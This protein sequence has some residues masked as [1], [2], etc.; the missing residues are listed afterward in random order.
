MREGLEPIPVPNSEHLINAARSPKVLLDSRPIMIKIPGILNK[1]AETNSCLK[2][3]VVKLHGEV[4]S[5]PAPTLTQQ[6]ELLNALL[7]ANEEFK[8]IIDFFNPR[9]KKAE[10]PYS[11]A[12]SLLETIEGTNNDKVGIKVAAEQAADSIEDMLIVIGKYLFERESFMEDSSFQ[13]LSSVAKLDAALLYD[14]DE[15]NLE[16]CVA[17]QKYFPD[18]G[19]GSRI[20]VSSVLNPGSSERSSPENEDIVVSLEEDISKIIDELTR[21][22]TR[23]SIVTITG[24]GGIAIDQVL[25][26]LL[27]IMSQSC[28]GIQAESIEDKAQLLYRSLKGRKYLIVVDGLW[29][30]E[31]WDAVLR[32][33]RDDNLGSRI[34]ITTRV[35]EFPASINIAKNPPHC[36][37]P[38]DK[39]QSWE[40]LEK[41]VFGQE[42]RPEELN[43][44]G[45]EIAE[46]W[47][48]ADADYF[49][50]IVV[51]S[52]N[53]LPSHL[54][55]CFIYMG[56]FP[57]NRLIVV[58]K[59]LNLWI[60]NGFLNSNSS[61]PEAENYLKGL[62]D[63]NLLRAGK[64]S[65]DGKVKTCL[66]HDPLRQV[67]LREA[68][69]ENFM[70][71]IESNAIANG[72][73]KQQHLVFN[74]EDLDDFQLLPPL[75]N[76]HSFRWPNFG[77]DFNLGM[78]LLQLPDFK[79]L[80]VLDMYFV[81]FD[82]F[83][84]ALLNL[85]NLRGL[86]LNVTY[87][88]DTSICQLLKLQTVLI[89]GPW[90]SGTPPTLYVE[91]WKMPWLR[92]V[93]VEVPSC[94]T[95][96]YPLQPILDGVLGPCNLQ[97][98]SKI[99]FSSCTKE[100]ILL[101]VNLKQL[102][103]S[104]TEEDF[105]NGELT[106]CFHNLSLLTELE[107]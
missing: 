15:D 17:I 39:H 63:R 94:L 14:L 107:T 45:K 68:Q 69:K 51:L 98:L 75:P 93:Y 2:A 3:F 31:H 29:N 28:D 22:P 47:V 83:P 86:A 85:V 59:L 32:Y 40:L 105:K 38:L 72:L 1:V 41:L 81:P 13:D 34:L 87:E 54:K 62:I 64:R 104:E 92:N 96:P 26:H 60:A 71:V 78:I 8:R 23:L 12:G 67:C 82:T 42:G 6:R 89:Y 49:L 102:G 90:V 53:H 76:L 9:V 106:K 5:H 21:P 88:L 103:V 58:E 50:D 52:Y 100:V 48:S 73:E 84:S 46:R 10:A 4:T 55:A 30:F 65:L 77:S 11:M 57:A 27:Q 66:I 43:G 20:I 95:Y 56:A 97:S 80:G 36:M 35:M 19:V 79:R 70:Q 24:M 61:K 7:P 33:L 74:L 18:D 99:A 25:S 101:M 44:V 91:F 37:E 16:I